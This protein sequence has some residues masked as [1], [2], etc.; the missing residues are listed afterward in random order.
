M[1]NAKIPITIPEYPDSEFSYIQA[2]EKIELL[3]VRIYGIFSHHLFNWFHGRNIMKRTE[4]VYDQN[5]IIQSRRYYSPL[6]RYST[7]SSTSKWSHCTHLF[8]IFS[9]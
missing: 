9:V 8:G 6:Y 7:S 4:V 1:V 5:E 2:Q 3:L